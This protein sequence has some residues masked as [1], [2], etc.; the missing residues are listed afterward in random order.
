MNKNWSSIRIG[1]VPVERGK[2]AIIASYKAITSES[3]LKALQKK[4]E[5]ADLVEIRYDLIPARSERDLENLLSALDSMQLTYIFTYRTENAEEAERYYGIAIDNNAPAIDVDM[6]LPGIK[7]GRS[8]RFSS[9]HG[10]HASMSRQLL[11]RLLSS[12]P[13]VVK[14]GISYENR[15]DLL[16][17]ILMIATEYDGMDRPLCFSPM[18]KS[19]FMRAVAAY[20]ISDFVYA[21]GSGKTAQGQMTVKQYR[22]IF[23][24]Y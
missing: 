9:F 11:E 24:L 1:K 12:R 8:C 2:P 17:D 15:Q 10:D 14:L 22:S 21:S 19:G 7:S 20:F 23:S 13:D 16:S 18:G 5:G 4:K 6:R 3:L